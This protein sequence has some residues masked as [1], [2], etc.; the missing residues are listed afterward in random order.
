MRGTD[1]ACAVEHGGVQGNGVHQ[2][3]LAHHVD[4]ERLPCRNIKRI[5]DAQQRSQHEDVP[6]ADDAGKGERGQH[7]RQNHGRNLGSDY[8]PLTVETVGHDAAQRRHQKYRNLAGKT[9]RP[10]Q[11]AP[12]LSGDRPATTLQYFASM[13]Q[14]RR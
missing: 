4:Q 6:Y 1:N 2:V 14:S 8:D 7:Q 10:Q 5:H 3:F 13:S 12:N 11:T 9:C